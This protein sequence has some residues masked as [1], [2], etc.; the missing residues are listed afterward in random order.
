MSQGDKYF[1]FDLQERATLVKVVAWSE[2]NG[3]APLVASVAGTQPELTEPVTRI[4]GTNAIVTLTVPERIKANGGTVILI[5]TG[6][7]TWTDA[8]NIALAGTA[9]VGKAL[10]M[11]W[12]PVTGKWYPS[13]IA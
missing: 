6:I 11:T 2:G 1:G 4:S 12:E 8:G 10:H 5:P 13:Y 7:F 9:V 3:K